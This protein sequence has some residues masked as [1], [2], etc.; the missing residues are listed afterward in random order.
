M[1]RNDLW[2]VE[3]I[4]ARL[5]NAGT[6]LPAVACGVGNLGGTRDLRTSETVD[7]LRSGRDHAKVPVLGRS[8]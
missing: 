1:I 2:R 4:G 6:G 7:S 3:T 5:L 8:K